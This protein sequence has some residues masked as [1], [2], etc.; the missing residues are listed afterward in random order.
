MPEIITSVMS[1]FATDLP[2]TESWPITGASFI[3]IPRSSESSG[4]TLE[5]LRFFDWALRQ[6]EPIAQ[7]MEYASLPKAW[8]EQLP[9]LWRTV[10]DS[11]GQSIWP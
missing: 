10:H 11:A 1:R 4:G 7:G 2:G 8:I 3:L 5:V 9:P 6:G